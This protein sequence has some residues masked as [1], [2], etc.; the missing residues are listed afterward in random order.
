M[1]H[2]GQLQTLLSLT[3]QLG[4]ATPVRCVR[5]CWTPKNSI[6]LVSVAS[7]TRTSHQT[8]GI[9][10]EPDSSAKVDLLERLNHLGRLEV[11]P[12]STWGWTSCDLAA[13]DHGQPWA[14]FS[15]FLIPGELIGLR[16]EW[17]TDSIWLVQANP[18]LLFPFG[19]RPVSQDR[20]K[21]W[22]SRGLGVSQGGSLEDG[23]PHSLPSL[24]HMSWTPGLSLLCR[25][26]LN[27]F[28]VKELNYPRL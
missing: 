25:S 7:N 17:A 11:F 16:Q 13:H 26:V 20:G 10:S 14:P 18:P 9:T 27:Q 22:I 28:A 12:S 4:G 8:N 19:M 3:H 23:F 21:G 24:G 2:Y 6:K 1:A 15:S 5:S